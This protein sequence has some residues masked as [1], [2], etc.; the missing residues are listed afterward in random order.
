M[1][2]H[3]FSLN[4]IVW[5]TIETQVHFPNR[6]AILAVIV[7]LAARSK[8]FG[9]LCGIFAVRCHNGDELFFVQRIIVEYWRTIEEAF[10]EALKYGKNVNQYFFAIKR[11][12][13][14]LNTNHDIVSYIN[15]H[16]IFG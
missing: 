14:V 1:R 6:R 4:S 13:I 10:Y 8:Q 7:Q 2:R 5:Q 11:F 12:A 16:N 3:F 15:V 9:H